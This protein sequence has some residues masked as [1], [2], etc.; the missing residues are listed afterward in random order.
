MTQR[1]MASMG[2]RARARKLSKRARRRIAAMGGRASRGILK[3]RK[4]LP[5]A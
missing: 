2:G 3:P 4:R 5:A 1:E